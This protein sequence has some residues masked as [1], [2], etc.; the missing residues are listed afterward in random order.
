M[1]PALMV[2]IQSL[3]QCNSS[4]SYEKGGRCPLFFG[5]TFGIEKRK[6][7]YEE[8]FNNSCHIQLFSF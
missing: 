5:I 1:V 2:L 7:T 4:D 6:M 3:Y 8:D